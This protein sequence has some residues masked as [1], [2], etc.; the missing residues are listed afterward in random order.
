MAIVFYTWKLVVLVAF[1]VISYFFFL[2]IIFVWFIKQRFFFKFMGHG[3]T[4]HL[5]FILLYFILCLGLHPWHM[6]VPRLGD[7]S[8]LQL[9]AYT[10]ATAMPD[11]SYICDLHH[12][13]WT[14][15]TLNQLNGPGIAFT[16]TSWVCYC[17]ATMGT[18]IKGRFNQHLIFI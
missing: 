3:V 5:T 18:P 10:I 6:E 1:Q 16:D 17:W 15:W 9:L 7:K 13:S 11:P 8:E 14:C 2:K 12:S 4:E